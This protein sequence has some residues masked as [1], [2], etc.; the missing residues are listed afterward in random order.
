M[1]RKKENKKE[2]SKKVTFIK[3]KALQEEDKVVRDLLLKDVSM[4]SRHSL[5]L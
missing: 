4:M 3:I 2:K 1:A 5:K